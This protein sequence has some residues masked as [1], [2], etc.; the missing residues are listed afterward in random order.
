MTLGLSCKCDRCQ[1]GDVASSLN[2]SV[3]TNVA[4]FVAVR[5]AILEACSEHACAIGSMERSYRIGAK[6]AR[7]FNTF[8]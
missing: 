1:F 6:Q 5:K 4:H 3:D 8:V 2:E 7:V